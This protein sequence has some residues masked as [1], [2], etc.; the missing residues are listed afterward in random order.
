[1]KYNYTYVITNI[2]T[3]EYYYGCHQTNSLSDDYFGSGV[4]LKESIE[5]HRNRYSHTK[6]CAENPHFPFTMDWLENYPTRKEMLLAEKSLITT[7]V[8]EDFRNLN[9][10]PGGSL[11]RKSAFALAA[12]YRAIKY[13]NY[14]LHLKNT[15]PQ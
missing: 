3:N 14:I 10:I 7:T 12:K 15:S 4:L 1:M 9:L 11:H 2:L 6:E 8:L 13:E 5:Y